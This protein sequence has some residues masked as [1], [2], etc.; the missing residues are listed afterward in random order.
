MTRTLCLLLLAIGCGN[1]ETDP[2]P[3]ATSPERRRSGLQR[4]VDGAPRPVD[5]APPDAAP[6]MFQLEERDV[7]IERHE[8]KATLRARIP[9]GWVDDRGT[10]KP[11]QEN[12]GLWQPGV[13]F[14]F[15]GYY[16]EGEC[17]DSD[18]ERE[19]D[20]LLAHVKESEQAPNITS[21]PAMNA[22]RLDVTDLEKGPIPGGGCVAVAVR[23]PANLP[24]EV[25]G[26]YFEGSKIVCSRFRKGDPHYIYC[27]AR[28]PVAADQ[29]YWPLLVDA[30]KQTVIKD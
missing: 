10:F 8:M 15:G 13:S 5:A 17:R 14:G 19:R 4:E 11:V 28:L 12:E 1:K 20:G 2:A 7:P 3:T 9:T 22:V 29:R 21:D 27:S 24:K 16:C 30:C 18:F 23:K 26:P 25:D 6:P